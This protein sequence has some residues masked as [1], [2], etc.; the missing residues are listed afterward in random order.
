MKS[1]EYAAILEEVADVVVPKVSD[2]KGVTMILG[3]GSFYLPRD[4][5]PSDL[6]YILV[7]EFSFTDTEKTRSLGEFLEALQKEYSGEKFDKDVR[8]IVS[9]FLK[10]VDG[11][12]LN[13]EDLF[14]WFNDDFGFTEAE[15]REETDRT[16]GYRIGWEKA[17]ILWSSE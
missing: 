14:N 2:A 12:F 13:G 3:V 5:P 7:L 6:D 11:Y 15:L 4:K 1:K 9:I 10:D 8:S 16:A 17:P